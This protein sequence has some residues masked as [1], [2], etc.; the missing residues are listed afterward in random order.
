MVNDE[1][2]IPPFVMT[3]I[4]TMQPAALIARYQA[5]PQRDHSTF[6]KICGAFALKLERGLQASLLWWRLEKRPQREPWGT[7]WGHAFPVASGV[8]AW[9][10]AGASAQRGHAADAEDTGWHGRGHL[11]SA[12]RRRR[13]TDLLRSSTRRLQHRVAGCGDDRPSGAS[14]RQDAVRVP[15]RAARSAVD[16]RRRL[17][18]QGLP[19]HPD[20][21]RSRA[22]LA[23]PA[24]APT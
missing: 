3:Q 16:R 13:S 6:M 11:G 2:P 15:Q 22:H 23:R 1:L 17:D 21:D 19:T 9:R 12:R 24:T 7:G 10:R 14:R 4:E 5:T 18:Q 8:L 20:A